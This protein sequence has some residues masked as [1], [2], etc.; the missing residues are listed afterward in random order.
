M[1]LNSPEFVVVTG[2]LTDAKDAKAIKTGQYK[3]EW[4]MYKEAVRQGS[5]G[6]PWYDM[7]GNHD[8]FNLASHNASTNLYR[9]YGKSAKLLE[10][11]GIYSWD[12]VKPFGK[13]RF[14]VA[15]AT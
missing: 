12:I 10:N 13:Y 11:E 8:S 3:E 15:D 4:E 9:D 5:L 14:V 7:K 2:D 6:I 1:T